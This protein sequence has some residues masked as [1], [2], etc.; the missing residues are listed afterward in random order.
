MSE[1]HVN[2]DYWDRQAQRDPL[3]AILADATKRE[4]KWDAA[5][6]FQTGSGEIASILVEGNQAGQY[7]EI[8]NAPSR[9]GRAAAAFRNC[10]ASLFS[11]I[12]R[13]SLS[14]WST[15]SSTDLT[16]TDSASPRAAAARTTASRS[17]IKPRTSWRSASERA[18]ATTAGAESVGVPADGRGGRSR[19]GGA[20]SRRGRATT[21]LVAMGVDSA[22]LRGDSIAGAAGDAGGTGVAVLVAAGACVSSS[23]AA[24]PPSE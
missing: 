24:A 9:Y 12:I 22:A 5:R 7:E 17:A 16:S 1:L 2:Q 15:C 10:S 11:R 23:R 20:G 18:R 13:A 14:R 21:P 6:F 19:P 4:G 3:W 8:E